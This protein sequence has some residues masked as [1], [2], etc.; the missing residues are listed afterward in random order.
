MSPRERLEAVVAL[1]RC[2]DL[3]L[4]GADDGLPEL[5]ESSLRILRDDLDQSRRRAK[6]LAPFVPRDEVFP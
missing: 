2:A 1:L 3:M 6:N 4:E 5:G